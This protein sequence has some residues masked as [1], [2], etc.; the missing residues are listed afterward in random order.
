METTDATSGGKRERNKAENRA[1]ILKAAREVFTELG[2]EGAGVRD[3]VRRTS[4]AAGTFYNYF[5]D[6][7]A[8]FRALIYDLE[9][10]RREVRKRFPQRN[11]D[12]RETIEAG[13][14][15]YFTF[16]VEDIPMFEM[17]R[18]NSGVLGGFFE[19]PELMTSNRLTQEWL[20][21][22]ID[23]RDLPADTDAEYMAAVIS[24]ITWEIA[25]RLIRREDKDI[26]QP[27]RMA[28]DLICGYLEPN[29]RAKSK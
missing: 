18:R 3:I 11:R 19:D 29:K 8:I 25:V 28:S 27:T 24:G 4:L 20:Q 7:D 26:E 17:L 23:T 21:S 14:R 15:A 22:L 16:V 10:R 9:E 6:K 1:E 5:V 12:V 2:Y 13:F